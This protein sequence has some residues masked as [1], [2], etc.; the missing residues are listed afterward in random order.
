MYSEF[1]THSGMRVTSA[2][3]GSR[4]LE[5]AHEQ[6]PNVVV[7]DIAMPQMDGAELSRRLRA[8]PPT[9]D[10]PIIAVTG[11]GAASA[12]EAGCDVVLEKPCPPDHLLDVIEEMLA[13]PRRDVD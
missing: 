13:K 5:R 9:R 10:I 3:C 7:T 1:L 8:E 2:N 12:R 4:A 11:N 6:V